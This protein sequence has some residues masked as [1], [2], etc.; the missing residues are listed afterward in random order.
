MYLAIPQSDFESVRQSVDT[1]LG[2]PKSGMKS[3]FN[4]NTEALSDGN[5]YVIYR[6]A[7]PSEL[8]SKYVIDEATWNKSKQQSVDTAPQTS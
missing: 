1:A 5:I 8:V 6:N 2:L 4:P 7:W 3:C